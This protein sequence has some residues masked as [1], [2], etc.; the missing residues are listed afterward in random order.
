MRKHNVL[1]KYLTFA[2]SFMF[3]LW[4]EN[5]WRFRSLTTFEA[6]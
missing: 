3:V 4:G 2:S 1:M 5:R 6:E